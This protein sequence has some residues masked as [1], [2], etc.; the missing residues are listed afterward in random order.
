MKKSHFSTRVCTH[1]SLALLSLCVS[2]FSLCLAPCV[3]RL[4]RSRFPSSR[5]EGEQT[6]VFS[7][8]AGTLFFTRTMA[9]FTRNFL[10]EVFQATFC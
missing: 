3:R 6:S 8:R 4:L 2:L 10:E 1:R 9:V 5:I 7:D